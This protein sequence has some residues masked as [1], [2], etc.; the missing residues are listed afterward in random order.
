MPA[1]APAE[2]PDE[3]CEV[4]EGLLL[5]VVVFVVVG[6]VGVAG[7]VSREKSPGCGN[8]N[9]CPFVALGLLSQAVRMASRKLPRMTDPG[10]LFRHDVHCSALL[11]NTLSCELQYSYNGR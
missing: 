9:V 6:A 11:R 8:C 3:V 7:D 10:C 1:E 2:R 4:L 5:G